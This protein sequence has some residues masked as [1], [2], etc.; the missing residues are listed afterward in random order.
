MR[1]YYSSIALHRFVWN[2][3]AATVE[4]VFNKHCLRPLVFWWEKFQC[5]ASQSHVVK[6]TD[7]NRFKIHAMVSNEKVPSIWIIYVCMEFFKMTKKLQ[8]CPKVYLKETNFQQKPPPMI[9]IF[10]SAQFAAFRSLFWLFLLICKMHME[11]NNHT[12]ISVRNMLFRR[13][14]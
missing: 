3:P 1:N 8:L 6:Q 14:W 11:R 10:F 12:T 9:D 13:W 4:W 2:K 7:S 5:K